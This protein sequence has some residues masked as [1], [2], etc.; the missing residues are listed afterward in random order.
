MF[1]ESEQSFWSVER[2]YGCM[3]E[4]NLTVNSKAHHISMTE[5]PPTLSLICRETLH[6]GEGTGKGWH[7]NVEVMFSQGQ[8]LEFMIIMFVS[9]H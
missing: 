3:H 7:Y 9:I 6:V 1:D 2:G 4:M 8:A 5:R